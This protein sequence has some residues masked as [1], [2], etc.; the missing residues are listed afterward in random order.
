VATLEQADRYLTMSARRRAHTAR[1]YLPPSQCRFEDLEFNF[2]PHTSDDSEASES[3]PANPE[4]SIYQ[5]TATDRDDFH[6]E[7][8]GTVEF[9]EEHPF[10]D[11]DGLF[12]EDEDKH[13]TNTDDDDQDFCRGD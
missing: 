12:N 6:D 1:H 10:K 4:V 8:W 5:V 11:Y 13:E 2:R 3:S 9:A 7:E